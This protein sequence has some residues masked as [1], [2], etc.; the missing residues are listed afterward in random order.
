MKRIIF[1]GDSNTYGY[2]PRGWSGGRYPENIRWTGRLKRDGFDICNEGMNGRRVPDERESSD[3][4]SL[5]RSD[6]P[7]DLLMI[8]LGTN[9]ILAGLTAAQTAQKTER[10]LK[11]VKAQV[12]VPVLLT[13]PPHLKPGVWVDSD[14]LIEES[15]RLSKKL[16]DTAA[17]SGTYFC[18]AGEWDI[19][20]TF[21]GVHLSEHGNEVFYRELSQVLNRIGEKI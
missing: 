4:L 1:L 14:A 10:F 19:E 8:M 2:D 15:R 7:A 6:L 16:R 11:S 5:I 13:A 21:D 9:D 12:P 20:M 18:D 17:L 3:L